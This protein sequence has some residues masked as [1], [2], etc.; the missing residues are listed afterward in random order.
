MR[1]LPSLLVVSCL[2]LGIT[3]CSSEKE[4]EPL[5]KPNSVTETSFPTDRQISATPEF[6]EHYKS[7]EQLSKKSDIVVQGVVQDRDFFQSEGREHVSSKVKVT[8]V[9][10]GDGKVTAGDVVPFVATYALDTFREDDEVVVFGIFQKKNEHYS[11]D[12]YNCIDSFQGQFLVR[13]KK[14]K[15]LTDTLRNEVDRE[16]F[17][18]LEMDL[19]QL[20]MKIQSVK[21]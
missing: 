10:S 14:V 5:Q 15:R 12:H 8:K 16:T 3:G 2:F 17:P 9:L 18:T 21:K 6:V 4:A 11:Q 7:V 1:K 19:T 20:T 13:D